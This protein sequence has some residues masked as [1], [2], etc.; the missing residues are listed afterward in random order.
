MF[1]DIYPSDEHLNEILKIKS[2]Y[3]YITCKSG[4]IYLASIERV[5]LE[6]RRAINLFDSELTVEHILPLAPNYEW[7]IEPEN[8]KMVN[9]LGI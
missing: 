4:K 3:T 5:I 9:R 7:K 2:L 6:N 1:K 8:I